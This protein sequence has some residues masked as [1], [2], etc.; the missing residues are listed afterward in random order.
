MSSTRLSFPP[1]FVWG[2]AT[3]AY[4]IEGAT[5]EGGRGPSIWDTFCRQPGK[6][7]EGHTGDIAADHYHRFAEDVKLM[8]ELG[9]SHY[10]FS[11]AWPRIIPAGTGPVNPAG[12][13]FYRRLVDALLEHGIS[14][15]ATLYHWDLPQPLQD[16]GGWA[17]R[18]TAEAFGEYA[19]V[20][21]SALSDTVETWATINEPWCAS[22]L[23]YAEGVHAPGLT[24]MR[25]AF[26]AAHH[27]NLAH[28]LAVQALRAGGAATVAAVLNLAPVYAIEPGEQHET[29]AESLDTWRNDMWLDPIV[30]AA[31]GERVL[32]AAEPWGGMPVEHGD[33][34]VAASPIDWI[35]VNYYHDLHVP[36]TRPG[37][38]TEMGWPI[39]PSGMY[40]VLASTAQRTGLPL[41]VTENGAAFPDSSDGSFDDV[42]RVAFLEAHLRSVHRAIQ[43]GIDV[44]GYYVW[45]LLDNLEWSFG[46]SRRF[47]LVHVDYETQRRTPRSSFWRYHDIIQANGL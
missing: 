12:I 23:G 14:P 4:Q 39:T 18:L 44:R 41:F 42:D 26:R 1:G 5:K 34:E 2:A 22:Y 3:S 8:A 13:D 36:D 27:L 9:I 10:R 16:R 24:D 6:V 21:G 28:G 30:D 46:Y 31:Y 35:G 32:A 20:I 11:I 15:L 37:P 47:G 17:N 19:A 33:L 45:S 29:A 25:A 38:R 40:D 7:F 43:D